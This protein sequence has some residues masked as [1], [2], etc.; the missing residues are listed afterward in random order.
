[1]ESD[2][3]I[4]K[5][6]DDG[7]NKNHFILSEQ[8]FWKT[9]L[10]H[11]RGHTEWRNFALVCKFFAELCRIECPQRKLDSRISIRERLKGYDGT[12]Y[13]H[14]HAPSRFREPL[15]LPNGCL[16]GRVKS[17]EDGDDAD[18][19]GFIFNVDT[20]FIKSMTDCRT[21]REFTTE[22]HP[23]TFTPPTMRMFFVRNVFFLS[24]FN[25]LKIY[26]LKRASFL[27]S[28]KCELCEKFHDFFIAGTSLRYYRKCLT[29]TYVLIDT[30][31][32]TDVELRR[33]RRRQKIAASIIAYARE[34][35]NE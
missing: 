14:I 21:H 10:S 11:I 17:G 6:K 15:V 19:E 27:V 8:H 4:L 18:N 13:I 35:R 32:L 5:Q 12:L 24:G 20:G 33:R 25:C 2:V 16:H 30:V 7:D 34:L 26:N 29:A 31:L 3:K 1:M 9:V 28:Y 22:T 23:E